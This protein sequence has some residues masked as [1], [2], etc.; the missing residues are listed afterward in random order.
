M[1]TG[2]GNLVK[3]ANYTRV[4]AVLD[5][6]LATLGFFFNPF[7]DEVTDV[8]FLYWKIIITCFIFEIWMIVSIHLFVATQKAEAQQN[9]QKSIKYCNY[10]LVV[11]TLAFIVFEAIIVFPPTLEPTPVSQ[12]YWPSGILIY[13]ILATVVVLK[14]KDKLSKYAQTVSGDLLEHK[15]DESYPDLLHSINA[16]ADF[17]RNL[18]L[19]NAATHHNMHNATKA[20]RPE[21]NF[22][23]NP[24]PVVGP[25]ERLFIA[26]PLHNTAQSKPSLDLLRLQTGNVEGF[27]ND[28][29]RGVNV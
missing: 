5:V 26:N 25:E 12:I 21:I 3:Y 18:C 17:H 4:V 1:F 20:H 14:Y 10:W 8:P 7:N 22:Y 29:L 15:L 11:A 2:N 16:T 9:P 13:R 6:I 23:L 27:H 19:C 28:L 24:N